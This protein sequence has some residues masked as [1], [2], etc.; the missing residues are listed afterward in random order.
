[1]RSLGLLAFTLSASALL[2]LAQESR[3]TKDGVYTD[4]VQRLPAQERPLAHHLPTYMM[5]LYRNFR[6]NFSRPLDTL[7]QSAAQ[8]ADTVQSVMAKSKLWFLSFLHLILS[9]LRNISNQVSAH[10]RGSV[11]AWSWSCLAQVTPCQSC[12]LRRP[13]RV[14]IHILHTP[15]LSSRGVNHHEGISV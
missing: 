10:S 8:Q 2:L 11:R 14:S 7:E 13:R 15:S 5:H 3:K 1:M 4:S 9:R 12:S 6:S